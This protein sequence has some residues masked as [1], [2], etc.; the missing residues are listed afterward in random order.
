M[1]FNSICL[2]VVLSFFSTTVL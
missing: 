2:W 1:K